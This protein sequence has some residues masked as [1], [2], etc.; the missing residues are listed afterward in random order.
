LRISAIATALIAGALMGGAA[1]WFN[2]EIETFGNQAE[3]DLRAYVDSVPRD[4]TSVPSEL[5]DAERQVARVSR[6]TANQ[7]AVAGHEFRSF[8]V[9]DKYRRSVFNLR[10]SGSVKF[11]LACAVGCFLLVYFRSTRKETG[12]Q[13]TRLKVF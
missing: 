5:S 11:A 1:F 8:V 3:N 10:A 13:P 9:D 2:A 4:V 12:S 6:Y 7:I